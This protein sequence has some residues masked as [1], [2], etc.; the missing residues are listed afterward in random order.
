M[1]SPVIEWRAVANPNGIV[2]TQG[3]TGGG[4]GG[5]IP[6]GTSSTIFTARLYNNFAAAAGI[7]DALSCVLAVYDDTTHQGSAVTNVASQ[8]YI[9]VE[10]ID[11]NGVTTNGDTVFYPIGGSTKHP[12]PVN[13][14]TLG[15]AVA[16]YCT[17]NIQA[18]IP[19]TASQGSVSVGLWCEY[20]STS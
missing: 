15:G 19:S 18:V 17:V 3:L 14:G 1:A 12:I 13:G 16:N 5:A 4:F 2:S 9:Q 10:V 6:V 8:H 11:Y 20:S 7:A